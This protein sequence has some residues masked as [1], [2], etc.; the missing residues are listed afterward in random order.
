M[1]TTKRSGEHAMVDAEG[2]AMR[3][4]T[5]TGDSGLA[6]H[7]RR[8]ENVDGWREIVRRFAPYVH[9]VCRA[10]GLPEKDA[11]GVFEQVFTCVW[12]EIDR[13]E[14]DDALRARVMDLTERIA[15]AGAQTAAPDEALG[16]LSLALQVHEAARGLPTSQREL[17]QRGVVEGQDEA[18]IAEALDLRQEAV[19]EQLQ[20]ARM[21]L[22]GRLR[23]R[24]TNVQAEQSKHHDRA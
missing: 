16:T 10:N 1:E 12:T 8:S 14:D 17:L 24:G 3:P 6:P 18:T 19:A 4:C 22:R 23:R 5:G 7:G 11:E 20:A 13:L 15:A 2:S 21:R 9:A